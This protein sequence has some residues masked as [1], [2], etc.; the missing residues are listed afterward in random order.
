MKIAVTGAAGRVGGAVVD[1]AVS[2]GHE[3]IAIDRDAAGNGAGDVVALDLADYSAVVEALDGCDA[4]IHLAAINGPG[5]DP[6]HVVHDNNVIS[7][8]HALRAAIEVGISRICQ[9]SSINAIGGRFSRNPRYDYFPVDEQHPWYAEDP[10][11]LSKWICEQQADALTRRFKSVSIASL[12]LHGVV[13]HRT[14]ATSWLDTPE[15]VKRQLWGYTT[16]DAA[17]RAF[18][19]GLTAS[20]AGHEVIYVVASDT[21]ADTPSAELSA[22][23]YPGVPLREHLDGNRSFFDS[24]KAARILGWTRDGGTTP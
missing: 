5:R 16:S 11:S 10:Y 2:E 1:R 19:L 14:D 15:I 23:Y 9:A 18:M 6:D 21:M 22:K 12:R 8:Y 3:V 24:R 4:L 13:D 17:A 7:S 20:F